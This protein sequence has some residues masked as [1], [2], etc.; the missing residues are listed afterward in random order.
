MKILIGLAVLALIAVA[1]IKAAA[2]GNHK[3]NDDEERYAA[4]PLLTKNEKDWYNT[5]RAAL[6]HAHVLAQVALN[7]LVKAEG[8]KW[9]SAKNKIDPRSIDFVVMNAELE[10]LMAIEIDDR[11]HKLEKRQTDD[12]KKNKALDDAEI[13]LIR[14]PATPALP[15]EEVKKRIVDALAAKAR[16]KADVQESSPSW[17]KQKQV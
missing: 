2:K 17:M 1:L 14:F 16:K 5:I 13:T 3:K 10:V 11:S 12:A 9:R 4:K 7:Q 6:P 15:T 8:P